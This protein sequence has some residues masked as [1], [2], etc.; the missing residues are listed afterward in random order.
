MDQVK[1]A[2]DAALSRYQESLDVRRR[3]L[4]DYGVTANGLRAVLVSL[5]KCGGVMLEGL[6]Q[7]AEACVALREA[8]QIARSMI[9]NYG[10]TAER[11]E[12]LGSACAALANAL[13]RCPEALTEALGCAEE[14]VRVLWELVEKQG[15]TASRLHMQGIALRAMAAVRNRRGESQAALEVVA[16]ALD[17]LEQAHAKGLNSPE[18]RRDL[19]RTQE[20]QAQLQAGTRNLHLPPDF[21]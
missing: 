6:N 15:V 17:T 11:Q 18:W 4:L 3:L 10:V 2:Y 14:S 12:D 19:R 1:G 20:L 9:V 13:A 16:K 21:A 7:P 5:F 8:L